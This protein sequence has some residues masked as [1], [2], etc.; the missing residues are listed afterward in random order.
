MGC[1]SPHRAWHA[2]SELSEHTQ[3]TVEMVVPELRLPGEG[4][5][6]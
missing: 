2:L 6:T 3:G 4:G 5:C 1:P